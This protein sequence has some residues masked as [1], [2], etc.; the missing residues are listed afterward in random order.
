MSTYKKKKP[1]MKFLRQLTRKNPE[2]TVA[3]WLET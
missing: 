1:K 3:Y 2:M